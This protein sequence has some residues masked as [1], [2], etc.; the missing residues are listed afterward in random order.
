MNPCFSEKVAPKNAK[1][2][3]GTTILT[4]NV[5]Q[6]VTHILRLGGLPMPRIPKLLTHSKG[7]FFVRVTGPDGKR[8]DHNF[9]RDPKKTAFQYNQFIAEL[10]QNRNNPQSPRSVVNLSMDELV[11]QYLESIRDRYDPINSFTDYKKVGVLLS[12]L[13][14]RLSIV[15]FIVI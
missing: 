14:G 2:W 4:L 1:M 8:R 5:V 12:R 6:R 10:C 3:C 7:S 11:I 13:Y 15:S 9:G